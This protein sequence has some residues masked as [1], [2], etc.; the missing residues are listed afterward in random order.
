MEQES[1][2]EIEITEIIDTIINRLDHQSL[3]NSINAEENK[4]ISKFLEDDVSTLLIQAGYECDIVD[5]EISA[6]PRKD[7]PNH[8]HHNQQRRKYYK[9]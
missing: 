2:V 4:K 9:D 1:F 6:L 3:L 5:H 7:S 8:R